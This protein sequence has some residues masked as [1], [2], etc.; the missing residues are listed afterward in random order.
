MLLRNFI[1]RSPLQVRQVQ[2]FIDANWVACAQ[3]SKPL[4][5]IVQTARSKR[6][7]EQNKRLHALLREIAEQARVNGRQ[8]DAETW[9]E[10]ARRKFIGTEE[11]ALPDGTFV[12]RGISTTT[13]SVGEFT[14]FMDAIEAHA[15]TEL[16]VEFNAY[17]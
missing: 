4:E 15:V 13:L 10:W 17:A 1:L 11:I 3:D 2:A 14:A 8:F 6:S 9:K 7:I 16:G 12:E 5:V